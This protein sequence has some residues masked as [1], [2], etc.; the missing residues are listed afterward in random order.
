MARAVNDAA[1]R[2]SGPFAMALFGLALM[3]VSVAVFEVHGRARAP[4]APR[5]AFAETRWPFLLDQWGVGKAFTCTATDCGVAI[6][7]YLRPK[8]GFCNCTTGVSDDGELERV[9][10]NDL[11][12]PTTLAVG[13]GHPIEVGWMKGRSRPYWVTD[14][15][16]S[17]ILSIAFN[18]NCDVIV[19]MATLGDA[20]P[21]K[22]EPAVVGFLN[23]EIILAWAK[24]ELGL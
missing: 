5:P 21:A 13:P 12:S 9:G 4:Q 10:D 15:S 2:R 6:S 17:R 11:V 1:M 16:E 20:D 8:I 18:N 7:V 24:T 14:K 3:A 23:S 22:A 19:A